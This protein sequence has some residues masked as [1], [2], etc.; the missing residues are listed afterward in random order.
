MCDSTPQKI[1]SARLP[2]LSLDQLFDALGNVRR[3][4]VLATL[5]DSEQCRVEQVV[6]QVHEW[7]RKHP[8]PSVGTSDRDAVAIS[9][10]HT[11]VPKLEAY[12]LLTAAKCGSDIQ[13]T[14]RTTQAL[15]VLDAT[16]EIVVSDSEWTEESG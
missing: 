15:A 16:R 7:E 4:L 12:G 8:D 14:D 13:R 1:R 10:Q 3:R 2:G 6:T 11:H 9:I 5:R